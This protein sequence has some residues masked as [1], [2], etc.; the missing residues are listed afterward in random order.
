MLFI[1]CASAAETRFSVTAE[2]KGMLYIPLQR[3]TMEK[4]NC[5]CAYSLAVERNIFLLL[6][7][8]SSSYSVSSLLAQPCTFELRMHLLESITTTQDR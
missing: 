5:A 7:L 4:L 6:L 3:N 1:L 2:S 8:T